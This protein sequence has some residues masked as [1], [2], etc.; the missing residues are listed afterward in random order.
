MLFTWGPPQPSFE[1]GIGI[2]L[3]D[4]TPIGNTEKTVADHNRE[5]KAKK[6]LYSRMSKLG[7]LLI[8]IGF[9]FQFVAVWIDRP[10]I[11]THT[12]NRPTDNKK[13]G[14]RPKGVLKICNTNDDKPQ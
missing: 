6:R 14:E 9:G 3:E 4:N 13:T 11:N 10:K 5:V 1:I 12:H 8:A 7:L 2:G